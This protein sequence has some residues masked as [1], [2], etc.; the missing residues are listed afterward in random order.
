V[1][2]GAGD[3]GLQL[4]FRRAC[5]NSVQLPQLA[6]VHEASSRSLRPTHD[7]RTVSGL[8]TPTQ[9]N[10]GATFG[11]VQRRAPGIDPPSPVARESFVTLGYLLGRT[12]D[13]NQDAVADA[14]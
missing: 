13:Q 3:E 14:F 12:V 4:D 9:T 7:R 1:R 2:H 8:L 5:T 6:G 11:Q 10:C